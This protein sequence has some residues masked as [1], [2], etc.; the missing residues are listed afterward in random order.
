MLYDIFFPQIYC[1]QAA[2]LSSKPPFECHH[3]FHMVNVKKHIHQLYGSY[4]VLGIEQ[5]QVTCL[6]RRIAAH[7][8]YSLRLGIKYHINHIAVH[9][10]TWRIH[11]HHIGLAVL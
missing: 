6:C 9:A 7:L 8:H 10:G 2:F 1:R 4:P 5:C 3:I 11:Y